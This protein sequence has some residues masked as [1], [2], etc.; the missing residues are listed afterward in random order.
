MVM[1]NVGS[2]VFLQG[3]YVLKK[4]QKNNIYWLKQFK[5]LMLKIFVD[6]VYIVYYTEVTL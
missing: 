4:Q 3:N 5:L 1:Y 2:F 6:T